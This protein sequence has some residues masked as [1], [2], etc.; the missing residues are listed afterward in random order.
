M[1]VQLVGLGEDAL[2]VQFVQRLVGGLLIGKPGLE[3]KRAIGMQV[4]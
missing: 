3:I 1:V 4:C 2:W